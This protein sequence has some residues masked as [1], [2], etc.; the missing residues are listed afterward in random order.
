MTMSGASF[1]FIFDLTL[2]T[3]RFRF[4]PVFGGSGSESLVLEDDD[5]EDVSDV[6][7]VSDL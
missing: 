1:G 4:W 5:P 3:T 2:R 7:D 6:S